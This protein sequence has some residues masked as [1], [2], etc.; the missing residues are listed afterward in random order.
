MQPRS[1]ASKAT[2]S[3]APSR[4]SID[5]FL[6]EDVQETK[7]ITPQSKQLTRSYSN[8]V[9]SKQEKE[10]SMGFLNQDALLKIGH[11]LHDISSDNKDK[12][13]GKNSGKNHA[14]ESFGRVEGNEPRFSHWSSS[15]LDEKVPG[16]SLSFETNT[17]IASFR[18]TELSNDTR[19]AKE[20]QAVHRSWGSVEGIETKT[21]DYLIAMRE[22]A[23]LVIQRWYRRVKIRKTAGAA[24]MKRMMSAKKQ[25][26]EARMSYER[27]EVCSL[28]I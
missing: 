13:N 5:D 17:R 16:E 18:K 14:G 11:L 10:A 20:D 21:D 1:F 15:K 8:P 19:K 24:A 9:A 6:D 27:E 3:V 4:P 22:K 28:T 7:T 26:L 25:E 23:A 12:Q 2:Y